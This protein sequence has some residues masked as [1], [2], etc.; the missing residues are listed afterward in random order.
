MQDFN[1]KTDWIH[2]IGFAGDNNVLQ[3]DYG[4][5]CI[6]GNNTPH[7]YI[8]GTERMAV[9]NTIGQW[10]PTGREL[11]GGCLHN[12]VPELL[13]DAVAFHGFSP[14]DGPTHY[15]E[16]GLYR[17]KQ[18]AGEYDGT[19]HTVREHDPDP[20]KVFLSHICFGQLRE[21]KDINLNLLRRDLTDI[22][23]VGRKLFLQNRL[24]KLKLRFLEI[25]QELDLMEELDE[26]MLFFQ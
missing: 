3:Y 12:T 14:D 22:S 11:S 1:K 24:P 21:D 26:A 17:L 20:W 25:I 15:V 6:K 8:T 7:F 18:N 16:N 23:E 5:S 10:L 19:I 13:K 9:Q 2:H 4:F